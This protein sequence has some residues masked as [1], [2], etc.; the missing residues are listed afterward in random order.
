MLSENQQSPLVLVVDD[1]VFMRGMLQNLL[2]EQGYRV[3]EAQNGVNALEEFQHCSPDLVLMD[4]AMPVMDGFMA[5]AQ[6]KKLETGA[7][8]P[9]IMITALDD[10]QSVNRAFEAGATEYITKPVHWSVL[11]HRVEIILHARQAAA[12]LEA[13]EARFR[14]IFEQ[15]AM[16]IAL[17]TMTGQLIQSNPAAKKMLGIEAVDLRGKLF[18]KFF[19]PYDTAVEKEFYQQLLAGERDYYQMEKYFFRKNTPILW[20]RL[21]TSLVREADNTPQFII[22]MIE[23]ITE[24]K[25]A[26][27]KQR[28]AAKVFETTSD[29]IMI[30]NA[31][32]HI[33][34]VNQAFLALTGYSYE[35][36]LDKNPRILQSGHHDRV[37]YEEMWAATRE[38]GRWRGEI[39]NQRKNG[40]IYSSWMSM[41]AVR[42][43]HNEV[44]HYVAVYSDLSALKQDDQ[45]LRLLTHYD[46]LTELPNRLLFYE[47]LTRACRQEERLA[48]LYLDLDD[49]K[50]INEDFGF[51]VGDDFIKLIAHRLQQCVR[52]GDTISRLEGDEFGIILSPIHQDYDVRIIVEK[53]IASISEPA[54]INGQ[55]PQIDCNVGI[56]FY[57]DDQM[58][59][60]HESVEILIQ[61]ADMAMYLAKEAGINTYHIYSESIEEEEG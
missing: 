55:L 47:Y 28:L 9:V 42:G 22:Q 49:F 17:V 6:L 10:E 61:H 35:E 40:E 57:P 15:A 43:E 19:Y 23:D 39:W 36:V 1:D 58:A 41:S 54:L 60:Q 37:F 14:G 31:E 53:I 2:E 21:T 51:D 50:Q 48:L 44:T 20:A 29:G 30:T 7:D 45:R 5:C 26:Q 38:T 27:A 13:S 12:A 18:N 52:E 34:D 46:S 32:S 4:A 8:I 56:S 24:R 33:I 59:S 16:G 11:R 3:T 25:R